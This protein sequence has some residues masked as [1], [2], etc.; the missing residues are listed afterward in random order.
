LAAGG[1]DVPGDPTD[2]AGLRATDQGTGGEDPGDKRQRSTLRGAGLAAAAVGALGVVYGDIGTSPLYA[3]QAVFDDHGGAVR[4]TADDVYGVVSM[5][6]WSLT[7]IV[8]IKYVLL[9]MRADNDGE[10]GVM[11]LAALARHSL[12]SSAGRAAAVVLTLGMLGAALFYGDSVITPA[13]SV[14]SAVQ[15][16]DVAVPSLAYVVVPV[17]AV[18]LAVLFMI[19]SRGTHR[20]AGL[21]GPIMVVWFLTIGAIGFAWVVREPGMLR[22]LSPTYAAAFVVDHP[23]Q[24]FIAMGAIVLAITG[25]EALYADMGHFGAPPI[26]RAWFFLVYPALTLNYLAQGALLVRTPSAR[27]NPFFLLLPGWAQLPMVVLATAATVIASQ[28]VISGAFSMTWQGVRLGAIPTVRIRHTSGV[29]IGQIY[30]PSVNVLLLVAVLAVVFIFRSSARLASAYGVAVTGTFLI[31][32]ALLLVVARYRWHW[33]WWRLAL[34]VLVFGGLELTF[35]A[36]NLTKVVDGG[37]LTLLIAAVT[38]TVMTTWHRGG[39]IVTER[40]TESEGLLHS[41][42]DGLPAADVQRVPGLAVYPHLRHETTP[43][44]LRANARYDHVLHQCVVIMSARTADVPYIPWERR[45]LV[46][47]LDDARDDIVHI[48]AEFG[49]M[50]HTDLPEALRRATP[51]DAA[52]FDGMEPSA[53]SPAHL[54]IDPDDA[55]YF[56]SRITFS[57]SRRPGMAMWRKR[58]FVLLARNTPTT[59]RS[60]GL[61]ADRT[62]VVSPQLPL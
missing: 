44:A 24:T 14:L 19:Q 58:L 53:R 43:L 5:V 3:M 33:R 35:F 32:T 17:S 13:I 18:I 56:L 29:Q 47:R 36:A 30:V 7:L 41:F 16:L 20:V 25:A 38:F 15:G 11:A 40:R 8:S 45:I 57:V 28:A 49:F 42:L 21:F 10:G 50:D 59:A 1:D 55:F 9:V 37:W 61:P 31:T 39:E 46:S 22:G 52:I 54:G 62:L 2:H 12:P 60:L 34:V 4:P 6:F 51:A 27:S 48:A 26:R 23:H